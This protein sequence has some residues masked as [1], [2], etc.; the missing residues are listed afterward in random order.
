M[1]SAYITLQYRRLMQLPLLLPLDSLKISKAS[2]SFLFQA[3]NAISDVLS[4]AGPAPRRSSQY[5]HQ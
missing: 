3:F 5:A 4:T 1:F 2:V